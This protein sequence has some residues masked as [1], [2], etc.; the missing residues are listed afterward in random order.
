MGFRNDLLVAVPAFVGLLLV[1]LPHDGFARG[2]R[3]LA[4]A[5]TYVAAF[6]I[7]LSPMLSIYR[8]GGGNSSQHLIVLGLSE[9]FNQELGLDSGGAYEWGYGYSD[10]FAHALISANATR[11]LGAT[12]FL[13]LYGP[14]YD[15]SGADYL[16]QVA[17]NF[18]ADMLTRAYASAIR[19]IELPYNQ[20]LTRTHVEYP[21]A[22]AGGVRHSRPLSARHGALLAADRRPDP[23]RAQR[24]RHSRRS[25]RHPARALSLRVSGVAIRRPA[26][27]PSRVH[28]LVGPWVC[29]V[30]RRHCRSQGI[31][32]RVVAV[33]RR[34]QTSSRLGASEHSSGRAAC[35]RGSSPVGAARKCFGD[36]S[37]NTCVCCSNNI[38]RRRSKR[39]RSRRRRSGNGYVR[40]AAPMDAAAA[41]EVAS[42]DAVH[43]ELF[44]AEFGGPTCDS[45][46]LD[47]VFRYD[48]SEPEY[49][50]TRTLTVQPPLSGALVRLML[51]AYFHR[52]RERQI[53]LTR[54]GL[55]GLDIPESAQ[56]CLTRFA[57]VADASRLPLLFELR[58]RPGWKDTDLFQTIDGVEWRRNGE[59]V[60]LVYTFPR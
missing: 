47:A 57:R 59:E 16:S 19:V 10:E 17:R 27:L 53:P 26:L 60:P 36:F 32:R 25:L 3:N 24:H 14:E 1:F 55:A 13:Q 34:C 20:R 51:P 11:R 37:R 49:D 5:G 43:P 41:Q 18:P 4:L 21:A 29:G 42:G 44:L 39:R 12:S 7:A 40:F 54:Y 30:G 31:Q 22:A 8:T 23:V 15:R 56:S 35:G 58:L 45:V 38:C 6:V 33:D 52:A 2:W 9:P 46:K 28:R 48:A 50:F